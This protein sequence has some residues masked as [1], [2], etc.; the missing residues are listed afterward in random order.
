MEGSAERGPWGGVLSSGPAHS[1]A[2]PTM[3]HHVLGP[4]P[5]P[6]GGSEPGVAGGL[7]F[8]HLSKFNPP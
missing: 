2:T 7:L 4:P 6:Q 3:Q 8:L 1:P 5:P